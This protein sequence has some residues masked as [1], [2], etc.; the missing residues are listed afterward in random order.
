MDG[1]TGSAAATDLW[2]IPI[3]YDM[4]KQDCLML[5]FPFLLTN[6]KLFVETEIT[7][8]KNVMDIVEKGCLE[9]EK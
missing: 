6:E 3:P 2:V 9:L 1:A 8:C 5:H 7:K 4:E